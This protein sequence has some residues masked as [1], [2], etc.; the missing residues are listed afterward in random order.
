MGINSGSIRRF[1]TNNLSS[2]DKKEFELSSYQKDALIGIILGD[3]YLE[4]TKQTWNT[5]L[6]VDQIYPNQE[7]FVRN[8]YSLLTPMIKMS[9]NILTRN[10]KRTGLSTQS[11][12]F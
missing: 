12:Y 6:R 5:R 7:E 2:K 1:S 8:M 10:D 11:I 3:G 4:R 9:P